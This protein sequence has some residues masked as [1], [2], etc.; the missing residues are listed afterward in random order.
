MERE[1]VAMLK[2]EAVLI[3]LLILVTTVFCSAAE[4]DAVQKPL[5]VFGST[6]Y[7]IQS[8][9]KLMAWGDSFHGA[10]GT[11]DDLPS[12]SQANCMLEN[13][14][15]VTGNMNLGLAIDRD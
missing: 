13:A 8:D 12:F 15:F 10:T 1:A 11:D 9:G 7:A 2:K 5:A 6:Y 14:V 4:L 3:P